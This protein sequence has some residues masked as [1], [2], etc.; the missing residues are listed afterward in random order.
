MKLHCYS[1]DGW[2]EGIE[3][4]TKEEI[5][6]EGRIAVAKRG[7]VLRGGGLRW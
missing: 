4:K 2:K 5:V 7:R 6:A 3:E 1:S